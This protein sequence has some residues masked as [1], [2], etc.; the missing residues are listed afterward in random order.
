MSSSTT[1]IGRPAPASRHRQIA[2]ASS[3]TTSSAG[4]AARLRSIR[5][6]RQRPLVISP[7]AREG[8]PGVGAV[9]TTGAGSGARVLRAS[10]RV[11]EQGPDLAAVTGAQGAREQRHGVQPAGGVP[12]RRPP[13]A[14]PPEVVETRHDLVVE[15]LLVA[16]PLAVE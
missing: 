13:G 2:S 14:A 1:L 16:E 9:R 8:Y 3:V 11:P 5:T 12:P 6:M 15:A 7:A 10:Q 4:T